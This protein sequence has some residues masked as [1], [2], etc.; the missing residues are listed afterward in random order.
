[1][2]NWLKKSALDKRFVDLACVMS[3]LVWIWLAMTLFVL[4]FIF[5]KLVVLCQAL[6]LPFAI[7]GWAAGFRVGRR[8]G[9]RPRWAALVAGWS[10]LMSAELGLA[11]V[12]MPWLGSGGLMP[13]IWA[14]PAL[15]VLVT[16]GVIWLYRPK[17]W[18]GIL[19]NLDGT[20][21]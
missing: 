2:E 4:P 18:P 13:G 9:F 15:A 1:M 19:A 21:A 12:L 20:G 7:L 6:A 8:M 5:W 17:P 10:G 3:L 16:V 11:L 14:F